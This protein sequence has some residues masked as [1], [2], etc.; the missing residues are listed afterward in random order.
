LEKVALG[1]IL[2]AW[3]VK[4]ELLIFPLTGDLER[5]AQVEKVFISDL[6]GREEVYRIKRSRIFQGK[7]LLQ[8]EG[9]EDREKANSLRG[10]YLEIPKEDVP[11]LPEGKYYLF[12]LIG[13]QVESLKGE[14]IGEVKE[15]LSFPANYILVVRKERKEYYIPFTKDVIKKI[16]IKEK[17]ITIEPISGLLE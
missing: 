14:K 6:K 7:V 3:G 17:L 5:F 11:C 10:K 1:K 13:S 16:G 15:V 4:G 2:R 8:L 9:I 12:D